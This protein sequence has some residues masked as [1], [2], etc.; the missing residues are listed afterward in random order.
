VF[1]IY[2]EREHF[3]GAWMCVCEGDG[4]GACYYSGVSFVFIQNDE[5]TTLADLTSADSSYLLNA[6]HRQ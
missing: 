4:D 5:G 6:H 1:G 3:L 2:F